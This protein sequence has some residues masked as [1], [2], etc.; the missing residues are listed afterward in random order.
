MQINKEV[1]EKNNDVVFKNYVPFFECIN[2]INNT[3][4]DHAKDLNIVLS[5]YNLI[6]YCETN[7][8]QK[9][10]SFIGPSLWNSLPE[11]IKKTDNL[12]TFKHK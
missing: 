4:V 7:M 2:E 12:N 5:M 9:A 6:K 10:I 3:Q 1:H 8:G 11:L